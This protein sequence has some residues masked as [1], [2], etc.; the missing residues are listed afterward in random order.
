MVAVAITG[1]IACGKSL[2]GQFVGQL[3][4][5]VCEADQFGHEVLARDGEAFGAVVEAFGP[6]ILGP[7]GGIDR[8]RLGAVVFGDAVSLARLNGLTHPP[9]MK[10]VRD[11]VRAQSTQADCAAAIIPLLYEIGDEPNWDVVI[12]VASP[13]SEQLKRLGDRGLTE[14]QALERIG[15]QWDQATKME[16]ADYVIHNCGNRELLWEQTERVVRSIRGES[17]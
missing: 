13:R 2:V 1:G 9:I 3:G 17:A 5:P 6:S 4:V 8:A 7:D 16:R 14:A 11:W 12:C 10:K 15:A